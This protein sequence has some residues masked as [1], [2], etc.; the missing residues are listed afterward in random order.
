MESIKRL[1]EWAN[2]AC[3]ED[4]ASLQVRV[5]NAREKLCPTEENQIGRA[6]WAALIWASRMRCARLDIP[7][8][9]TT[10]DSNIAGA[11]FA[12]PKALRVLCLGACGGA[13]AAEIIISGTWPDGSKSGS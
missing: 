13:E 7:Y 12:N 9:L 5:T 6:G 4:T 11:L 3:N 10:V 8:E 2:W 1:R